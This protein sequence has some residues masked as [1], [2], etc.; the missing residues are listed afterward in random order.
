MSKGKT[1]PRRKLYA[2]V[3]TPEIATKIEL[4]KSYHHRSN[5][6]D[7]LRYLINTEAEKILSA[8]KHMGIIP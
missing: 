7:L 2:I 1:E 6:S 3:A 5:N 4:L 8:S